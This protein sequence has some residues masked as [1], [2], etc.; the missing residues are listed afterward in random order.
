MWFIKFVAPYAPQIFAVALVLLGAVV[1]RVL[2]LRPKLIYSVGHLSTV[3]VAVPPTLPD[4]QPGRALLRSASI[5]VSNDGLQPAKS[6]EAT[7]AFRP[8]AYHVH[9]M[10]TFREEAG[11]AGTFSLRFDSLAPSEQ[12]R[13]EIVAF[14]QDLPLITAIRS[15]DCTGRAVEMMVQRVWPNW[16]IRTLAAAIFVGFATCIYLTFEAISWIAQQ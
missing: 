9:P 11:A 8:A 15:D 6:V 7:F 16:V 3:G 1:N 2:R 13:I 4:E 12:V 14:N 10:R 5:F